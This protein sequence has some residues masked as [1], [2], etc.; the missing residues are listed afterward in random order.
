MQNLDYDDVKVVLKE[1]TVDPLKINK[2]PIDL[3]LKMGVLE[4]SLPVIFYYSD[5]DGEVDQR[6]ED[7]CKK[8]GVLTAGAAGSLIPYLHPSS[9]HVL[10]ES[11]NPS[12][13]TSVSSMKELKAQDKFVLATCS[14][15]ACQGIAVTNAHKCAD[16]LLVGAT[17][18]STFKTIDSLGMSTPRV[19]MTKKLANLTDTIL[20]A[21]AGSAS[22]TCKAFVAGADAVLINIGGPFAENDDVEFIVSAIASSL[23]ENLETLCSLAGVN[24]HAELSRVCE[25]VTGK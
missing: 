9:T 25:L 12:D 23:K 16:A 3:S 8:A 11:M 15:F 24:S 10:F 4:S 22:D 13:E 7:A 18:P 19:S 21:T 5:K 14:I 6:V 20:V 17:L 1:K 2:D